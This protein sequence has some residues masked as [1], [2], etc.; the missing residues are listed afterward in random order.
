M[1]LR[2][3]FL[4][5]TNYSIGDEGDIM[6]NIHSLIVLEDKNNNFSI[7]LSF[8]S[9]KKMS[10]TRD[11]KD[12]R[13]YIVQDCWVTSQIQNQESLDEAKRYYR[14]EGRYTYV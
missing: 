12:S 8:T 13:Y 11:E 9:D 3:K 14:N 10:I 6:K 4:K 2:I 1:D 5:I 7:A